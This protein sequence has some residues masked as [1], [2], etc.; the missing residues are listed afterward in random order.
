MKLLIMN[1]K[2]MSVLKIKIVHDTNNYLKNKYENQI[3]N[4][5]D[6]LESN[7]HPDSG[8]DIYIPQDIEFDSLVN[9]KQTKKV[10]LQIQCA[11]YD[12]HGIP[13]GFYI[14]PRSSISKTPFRLAN[15]VGIIDSGYRGNLGA[16]FDYYRPQVMNNLNFEI[17]RENIEKIS[18][19]SRLLQICSP[20]LKPFRVVL[21]DQLDNTQRGADGFG[22]TGK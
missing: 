19:G 18:K 13:S 17:N 14:Y 21:V 12:S 20:D 11:M 10:D 9:S 4:L 16:Y 8:F 22:S 15:N 3:K 5:N 1:K 2:K 6:N 7:L